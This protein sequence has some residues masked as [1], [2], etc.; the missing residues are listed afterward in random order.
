M[1]L[2]MIAH[3]KRLSSLN[4]LSANAAVF[5]AGFWAL[6]ASWGREDH[7]EPA[8]R[9]L[10]SHLLGDTRAAAINGFA[11]HLRLDAID[12]HQILE[13]VDIEGG[14]I[15]DDHRL[16]LDLLHAV[17][18]AVIM[19]IFV[20][21]AQLPRFAQQNDTSHAQ[22][23]N[24]ALALDVPDV[25]SFMREAFPHKVVSSQNAVSFDEAA[26]YR[27][28]GI[29]DY[30]RLETEILVPMEKAY[31]LIREIGTGITHHFGAFG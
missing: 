28:H 19:R 25:V 16:E 7:I 15:P 26:S 13:T 8:L 11:H 27:P 14:K 22:I 31:E 12:L 6:R 17:R 2:E 30:G 24:L 21:A 9:N 1:L 4:A 20:L 18:L 5:D 23:L 29:D 10:A 3:G